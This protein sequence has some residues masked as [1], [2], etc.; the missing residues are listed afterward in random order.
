MLSKIVQ[1]IIK[2]LKETLDWFWGFN[3]YIQHNFGVFA[4]IIF[5]LLFFYFLL[6]LLGKIF[7]ATLDLLFYILVPSFVLAFLTSLF[8][9]YSFLN[10]LPFFVCVLL[11][12]NLLKS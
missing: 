6:V 2:Y 9:P 12:I 3:L 1:E 10:I 7:K 5:D 8:I 11:G 4:Q